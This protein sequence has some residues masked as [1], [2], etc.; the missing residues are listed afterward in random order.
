MP[1]IKLYG[2]WAR[3]YA[4]SVEQE[5]KA[6]K[7]IEEKKKELKKETEIKPKKFNM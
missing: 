1:N 3:K 5:Q 6:E 2:D 7:E 4:K